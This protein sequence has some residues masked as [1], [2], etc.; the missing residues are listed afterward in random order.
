MEALVDC[1]TKLRS[2]IRQGFLWNKQLVLE[3]AD[4][5]AFIPAAAVGKTCATSSHSLSDFTLLDKAAVGAS[6]RGA[7]LTPAPLGSQLTSVSRAKLVTLSLGMFCSPDAKSPNERRVVSS[8]E[9]ID[10]SLRK[11]TRRPRDWR[12]VGSV[13]GGREVV[14]VIEHVKSRKSKL[15]LFRFKP[16]AQRPE[17]TTSGSFM[18][19]LMNPYTRLT[20]I[21]RLDAGGR[22]LRAL[23]SLRSLA[24]Q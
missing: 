6:Q 3:S 18:D 14:L 20:Q 13:I 24:I 12:V 8:S 15:V 9:P 2:P 7:L 23:Q 4:Q 11:F 1:S 17:A 16:R 10:A 22:P 21:L 5:V 19:Y